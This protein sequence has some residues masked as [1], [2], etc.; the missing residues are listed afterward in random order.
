L[1]K[2]RKLQLRTIS[3]ILTLTVLLGCVYSSA[4]AGSTVSDY[5]DRQNGNLVE[6]VY[7]SGNVT[8]SN[9]VKVETNHVYT[10]NLK[11]KI[12]SLAKLAARVDSAS[13]EIKDSSASSATE[14]TAS[15][16]PTSSQIAN[17]VVSSSA[18]PATEN[19]A[20]SVPTSSQI[21]NS[22]VSS[23]ASSATESTAAT[24]SSSPS[25]VSKTTGSAHS[26]LA[27]AAVEPEEATYEVR[28]YIQPNFELT[29]PTALPENA[30]LEEN[31]QYVSWA[32]LTAKQIASFS[33]NLKFKA[34]DTQEGSDPLPP[35][36]EDQSGVYQNGEPVYLFAQ[37][38][39]PSEAPITAKTAKLNDWDA[40]TYDINLS[41]TAQSKIE[42]TTA[43]CDI[44]L[45]LDRSGSMEEL[46]QTNAYRP[47]TKLDALQAA[48]KKFVSDVADHSSNSR[49][50]VVSFASSEKDFLIFERTEEVTNHTDGLLPVAEDKAIINK[51][52]D[53][54]RASGG[55]HSYSG[56]KMA[57][58]I[59]GGDKVSPAGRKRAVIMFTDGEPGEQGFDKESG[60]K[61]AAATIN[62]AAVLKA[63]LGVSTSSNVS[64]YGKQDSAVSGE[65]CAALVYTV[66]VFSDLTGNDLTRVNNYMTQTASLNKYYSVKDSDAL[67][68]V[69]ET[70]SKEVGG[71]KGAKVTDVIDPRFELTTESKSALIADGATVTNNTNATQMITWN[72][73]MINVKKD[74]QGNLIPDWKKA[75]TVKAKDQFIGG[76]N[77]PTNVEDSSG[78][79]YGNNDFVKFQLSTVN[80]RTEF[81]VSD[82]ESTIFYGE[83]T[84]PATIKSYKVPGEDM[85]CGKEPTGTFS[86]QWLKADGTTPNTEAFPTGQLP[87]GDTY[88]TL[89][90]TFN[91]SAPT[92]DSNR[93]SAVGAKVYTAVAT[94]N[95]V[96]PGAA[97]KYTVNVIK[98]E[99]DIT[100]TI[101]KKYPAPDSKQ[102]FVF[103]IKRSNSQGGAVIDTFYEVITP[104]D[105]NAG[106]T[107]K[108][109]G[110]KKGFYTV[111]EQTGC[112][113]AWRYS[114][115]TVSDNDDSISD[116][117]TVFIGRETT[118]NNQ[119]SYFG[120]QQGNEKVTEC[121][122][123]TSFKNTLI[124]NKWL[125]D[126][127]V[128]VNTITNK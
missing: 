67:D 9:Q 118:A 28:Y 71:V 16:V 96:V 115:T 110:L 30:V 14:S 11:V 20:S 19:T 27:R 104:T 100:K 36:T 57:R 6:R 50:A 34:I 37:A 77:I 85:F 18:S 81:Y 5:V 111:T 49:V 116:I 74:T 84:P 82:M 121:P 128:V 66:G 7:D 113:G 98:G 64:F 60:Y 92:D 25:A 39:L 99:L 56:M 51:A 4:A 58:A 2:M 13:S 108:I 127:T 12:T 40:R 3:F 94:P 33:T 126:T 23:S 43:P 97:G 123:T 46:I 32:D 72:N 63:K 76:N 55:T 8:L 80:V 44:I 93:N 1:K 102:S 122:A 45:V 61:A 48:A 112:T 124:N 35:D 26:L 10:I 117:G 15:S 88:Y 29:T 89:K 53:S 125:G 95:T 52:I 78:V 109:T 38:G 90:A 54:L 17:S 107:Q 105:V 106:F 75:F 87:N 41:V 83:E 70:I 86:F 47:T 22:V 119:K 31:G 59:F 42:T 79:S 120:A 68:E 21:T 69:F 73:Q 101:D 24:A 62:M 114:Q 103:E 65:G 91:P